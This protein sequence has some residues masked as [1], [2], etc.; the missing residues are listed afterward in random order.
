VL[1]PAE[2]YRGTAQSP[3]V[4]LAG[5]LAGKSSAS[6]ATPVGSERVLLMADDVV[7][8]DDFESMRRRTSF[9]T[10]SRRRR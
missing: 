4:D 6:V 3:P 7:V 1:G 10:S 9:S 2:E 8:G 5:V